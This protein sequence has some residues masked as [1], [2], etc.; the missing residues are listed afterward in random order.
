MIQ[1]LC[2]G[3]KLTAACCN[4]HQCCKT[5]AADVIT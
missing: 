5:E 4:Y 2:A 1:I 3:L